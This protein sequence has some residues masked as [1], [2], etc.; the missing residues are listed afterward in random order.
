[1]TLKEVGFVGVRWREFAWWQCLV[2]KV[3][4]I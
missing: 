3:T 2:I 1:M 4:Q